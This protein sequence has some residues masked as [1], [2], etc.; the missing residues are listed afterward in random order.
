MIGSG[1]PFLVASAEAPSQPVIKNLDADLS[2]SYTYKN[3]N[4]LTHSNAIYISGKTPSVLGVSHPTSATSGQITVS[5]RYFLPLTG[6]QLYSNTES[7]VIPKSSLI[8][9]ATQ[10]VISVI[11]SGNANTYESPHSISMKVEDFGF[12]GKVGQFKILKP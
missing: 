6:V 12:T 1:Y 5:G 3:I 4:A 2:G 8:A 7:R 10:Q 9:S 11:P